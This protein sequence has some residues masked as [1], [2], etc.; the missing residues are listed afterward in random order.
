MTDYPPTKWLDR[1][2][3]FTFDIVNV[4]NDQT[5]TGKPCLKVLFK[6]ESGECFSAVFTR[7][8]EIA[9]EQIEKLLEVT[10]SV[11]PDDLKGKRCRLSLEKNGRFMNIRGIL[12]YAEPET[13]TKPNQDVPF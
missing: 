3:K 7:D 2:G 6:T 5:K 12:K 11:D 13:Q 4:K 8:I 1:E 9:E 10:Q